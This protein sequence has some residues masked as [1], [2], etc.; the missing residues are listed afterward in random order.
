MAAALLATTCVR[1]EVS[2]PKRSATETA[3]TNASTGPRR[4]RSGFVHLSDE[5]V[6]VCPIRLEDF[7][8]PPKVDLD[9]DDLVDSDRATLD[10]VAKCVTTGPLKGRTLQLVGHAERGNVAEY[11]FPLGEPRVD[12]VKDYLGERGVPPGSIDVTSFEHAVQIDE[13]GQRYRRVDVELR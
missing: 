2:Q 5:L 1:G 13:Q 4:A 9:K 12:N 8:H 11:D 6:R 7:L 3:T 10:E